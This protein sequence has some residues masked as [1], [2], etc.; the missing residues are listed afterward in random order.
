M[1]EITTI[2]ISKKTLNKIKKLGSMGESYEDVIKRLIK[3]AEGT[4]PV[5]GG[6]S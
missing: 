3:Y 5:T 1:N 6:K 4:D 2:K